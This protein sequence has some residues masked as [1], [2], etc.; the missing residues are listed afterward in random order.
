MKI[1]AIVLPQHLRSFLTSVMTV[2]PGT[3]RIF[4]AICLGNDSILE[5][6]SE[7]LLTKNT[8]GICLDWVSPE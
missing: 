5:S 2:H 7:G 1:L 6:H 8:G 3:N 4:V